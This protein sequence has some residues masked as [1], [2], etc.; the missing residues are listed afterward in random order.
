MN[1]DRGEG[2]EEGEQQKRTL[3][4]EKN[5]IKVGKAQKPLK[6]QRKKPSPALL[7]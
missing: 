2:A 3:M 6:E 4:I 5:R 1:R 7:V